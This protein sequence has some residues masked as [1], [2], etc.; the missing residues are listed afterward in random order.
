MTSAARSSAGFDLREA[1]QDDCPAIQAIYADHVLHGFGSF[2]EL[3]PDTAEIERRLSATQA[4]GLPYLIAAATDP[5]GEILG[6]A[7]AGRY[8][9]RPAYRYSLENSVYVRSGQE[10]RG[11]G[12]LLLGGL[13]E[14][15]DALGYRQLVAVIG[16]S[17]NEASIRLH[18][19]LGFERAGCL[20]AIGFK[21]GRWVDSVVMQRPLGPGS[22]TLPE[23]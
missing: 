2:E 23:S 10:G 13:I 18:E 21:H 15:C 9:T 14:R 16:D 8:R 22:T 19:R 17:A 5:T 7:Y 20:R 4:Q 3:P 1:R 11:V 12:R 6:F